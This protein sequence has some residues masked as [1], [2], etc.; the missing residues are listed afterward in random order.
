VALATLLSALATP[1]LALS[2]TVQDPDGKPLQGASVCYLLGDEE[3]LCVETDE[4]GFFDLM[5][6]AVDRIRIAAVGFL[7]QT[8]A[9]VQQEAPIKLERAGALWVR[10][11]DDTSGEAIPEGEVFLLLPSGRRQGPFP[12]NAKGVQI[13]TLPLG[14]YRVIARATDYVQRRSVEVKLKPQQMVET[15]LRLTHKS[16]V[17]S[18]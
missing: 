12:T 8:V 16:R 17:E 9:A 15:E 7:P 3:S 6:S 1:L 2:G 5:D 10:L 18:D 11:L 4:R 13:A 14:T